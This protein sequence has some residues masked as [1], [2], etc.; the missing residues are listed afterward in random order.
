MY[1]EITSNS[2]IISVVSEEESETGETYRIVLRVLNDS[3]WR[4]VIHKLLAASAEE[5]T[6]GISVRQEFYLNEEQKPAFVWSILLWG[7]L[8]EAFSTLKPILSKR[9]GP[10]APPKSLGIAAPVTRARSYVKNDGSVVKEVPLAPHPG[11]KV[12]DKDEV[13]RVRGSTASKTA[14]RAFVE[15]V[16]G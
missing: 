14:N 11:E 3:K 12:I 4:K 1:K 6:F 2:N 7:E 5:E 16:G 9:G 10:P 8:E 13:V 15:K